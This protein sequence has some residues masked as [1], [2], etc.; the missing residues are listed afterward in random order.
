MAP[1][2]KTASHEA[3]SDSEIGNKVEWVQKECYGDNWAPGIDFDYCRSKGVD[4]F[5]TIIM[6]ENGSSNSWTASVAG[7]SVEAKA[8]SLL[9]FVRSHAAQDDV[10]ISGLDVGSAILACFAQSAT[11]NIKFKNFM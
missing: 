6:N 4:A 5:P 2:W 3:S 11:A 1:V 9:D 8:Q 7:D 10:K